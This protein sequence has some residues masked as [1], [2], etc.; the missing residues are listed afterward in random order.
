MQQSPRKGETRPAETVS[1]AHGEGERSR[2]ASPDPQ[3]TATGGADADDDDEEEEASNKASPKKNKK[4]DAEMQLLVKQ[5]EQT[6]LKAQKLERHRSKTFAFADERQHEKHRLG[7]DG[8][9]AQLGNTMGSHAGLWASALDA[10]ATRPTKLASRE[11]E[12][13]HLKTKMEQQKQE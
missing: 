2:R 11:D 1:A 6:Q 13:K 3:A 7:G 10:T 9:A 12:I 4:L 5:F 8:P